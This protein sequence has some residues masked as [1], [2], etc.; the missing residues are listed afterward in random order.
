MYSVSR[1]AEALAVVDAG[2]GNISKA[3]RI[4]RVPERTLNSLVRKY[5]ERR[6][7]ARPRDADQVQAARARIKRSLRIGSKN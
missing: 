7:A 5:Q 1:K 4:A 6:S 2:G 3:A